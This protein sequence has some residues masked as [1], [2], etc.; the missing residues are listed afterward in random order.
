MNQF[1]FFVIK[2]SSVQW[3]VNLLVKHSRAQTANKALNFLKLIVYPND[4]WHR[5]EVNDNQFIYE[6]ICRFLFLLFF[7]NSSRAFLAV[8]CLLFTV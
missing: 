1:F 2:E 4:T 5:I 8:A 7:C 3:A 6:L